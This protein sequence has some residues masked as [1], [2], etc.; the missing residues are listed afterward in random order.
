MPLTQLDLAEALGLTA[1][2]INRV[3]RLL[4][5]EQVMEISKGQMTVLDLA[6]LT[7]IADFDP[8]YLHAQAIDRL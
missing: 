8:V 1:V 5:K 4:R 6:A 3:V 7:Q 2:H